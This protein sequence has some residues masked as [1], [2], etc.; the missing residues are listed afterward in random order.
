MSYQAFE[1]LLSWIGPKIK[2]LTTKIREP[3]T[4][5]EKLSV[6]LRCLM[7]GDAHVTITV[8]E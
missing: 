8:I 7:T 6:T 2:K 3:V 5:G 1:I 4:V